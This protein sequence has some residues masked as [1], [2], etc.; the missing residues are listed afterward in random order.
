MKVLTRVEEV[1]GLEQEAEGKLEIHQRLIDLLLMSI[2]VK[3]MVV[4]NE[5]SMLQ[6]GELDERCARMGE[7]VEN[8]VRSL[9]VTYREEE[10]WGEVGDEL[11]KRVSRV[12]EEVK[13]AKVGVGVA[14]ARG[15]GNERWRVRSHFICGEER[16]GV[17]RRRGWTERVLRRRR[18]DWVRGVVDAGSASEMD[19]LVVDSGSDEEVECEGSDVECSED[20]ESDSGSSEE[21]D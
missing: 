13:K 11:M 9:D 6:F 18:D 5:L 12:S 19:D 1:V 7:E 8:V 20:V 17:V 3:E 10:G 4:R 2:E 16:R 14:R 15:K 21:M